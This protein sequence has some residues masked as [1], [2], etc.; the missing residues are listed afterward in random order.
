VRC[1][2]EEY[3]VPK[4]TMMNNDDIGKYLANMK[5]YEFWKLVRK[6][7]PWLTTREAATYVGMKQRTLESWRDL[8]KGPRHVQMGKFIR[9]HIDVL[10]AWMVAK[11]KPISGS[12]GHSVAPPT[13]AV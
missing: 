11:T 13:A 7:R 3:E 6:H 9:Y 8:G 4:E 10:D 2:D 5:P 1:L 12:D